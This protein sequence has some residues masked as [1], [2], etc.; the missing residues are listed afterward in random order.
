LDS[1]SLSDTSVLENKWISVVRLQKQV[2]ELETEIAALKETIRCMHKGDSTVQPSGPRIPCAPCRF[3]L[4]Q[5]RDSITVTANKFV[6]SRFVSI[7]LIHC[8]L[9]V[10]KTER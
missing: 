8:V 6:D 10:V 9:V 7:H 1:N 2:M 3:E 5:H 4:S